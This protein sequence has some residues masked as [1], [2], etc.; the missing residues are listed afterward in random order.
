LTNFKYA[1]VKLKPA[2][3]ATYSAELSYVPNLKS[4]FAAFTEGLISLGP[5]SLTDTSINGSLSL[6]SSMKISDNSIDTLGTDLNLQPLRQGALS[7]M[8]GLVA[9]DTQG[10][11]SVQ[12]NASFAKDVSIKGKLS[13]G[14]ISPLAGSDVVVKLDSTT[15]DNNNSNFTVADSSGSAK[16]SINQLGD[17]IASGAA[18]FGNIKIVR[19]AQADTSL[20]ETVAS[21]SAG[22][23]VIK[24]NQTER[25]ILTPFV[26]AN[27]LIYITPT[28]STFGTNPYI[29]RQTEE[30]PTNG[31]KGSFTIQIPQS[32]SADIKLNWWI[33]N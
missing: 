26:T 30:N 29:A 14:I 11:L 25:T 12:G 27:S 21:G 32:A 13:A 23:A 33:I 7:I 10:N 22:M 6:G 28:S 2:D 3:I 16:F 5:T 20:T 8:G 4:D 15:Q 31:S 18:Q 24:A 9:V 17:V 19:G 1:I